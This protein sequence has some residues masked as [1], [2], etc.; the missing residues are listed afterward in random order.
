MWVYPKHPCTQ[1][2]RSHGLAVGRVERY[3]CGYAGF[4]RPDERQEGCFER[5]FPEYF[6][7]LGEY[8]MG[9]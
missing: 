4:D 8:R 9:I 7:L 3:P 1:S 2:F 5:E 6:Y